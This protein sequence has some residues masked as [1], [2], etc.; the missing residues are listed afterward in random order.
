MFDTPISD[1]KRGREA[2]SG[3]IKQGMWKFDKA[4]EQGKHTLP[5]D[6]HSLFI[7]LF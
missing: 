2:K 6:T 5:L 4:N 1:T 7:P 3:E